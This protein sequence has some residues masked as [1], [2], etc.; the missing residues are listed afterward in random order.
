M[1]SRKPWLLS[2]SGPLRLACALPKSPNRIGSISWV[3]ASG[4]RPKFVRREPRAFR[5]TG[6]LCPYDARIDRGLAHPGAVPA[7]AA[8]DDVL[9]AD[10]PRIMANALRDQHGVLDK[11]GLRLDHAG[12]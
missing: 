7:I 1:K 5:Q 4:L 8:G 10:K 3:Q 2:V 6:K 12:D 9:A 11:I